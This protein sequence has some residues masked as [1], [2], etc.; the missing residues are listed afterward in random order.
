MSFGENTITYLSKKKGSG[1]GST[2][3]F[4]I[5]GETITGDV[6]ELTTDSEG[7]V[8]INGT[9]VVDQ[10]SSQIRVG[11]AVPTDLK[12]GEIFGLILEGE[13]E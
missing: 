6:V 2:T 11:E 10:D 4:K 8:A 13:E 1:D 3:T 7:N 12:D 9:E 5:N